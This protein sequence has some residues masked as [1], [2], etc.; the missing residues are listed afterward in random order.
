MN[1]NLAFEEMVTLDDCLFDFD[2][3]SVLDAKLKFAELKSSRIII[4]GDFDDDKWKLSDQLNYISLSFISIRFIF[5]H[6]YSNII[7]LDQNN[8][9]NSLKTFCV[10]NIGKIKN[11]TIQNFLSDLRKL[12]IID[13]NDYISNFEKYSLTTPYLD[14]IF[15]SS[16]PI[17]NNNNSIIQIINILESKKD[18]YD[19]RRQRELSEYDSYFL[20]NDI[21]K[22]YWENEITNVNKIYFFPLWLWWNLSTIIPI[23]PTEFVLIPRNCLQ[24][25]NGEYYLTI[26]RTNL[27]GHKKEIHN[28][29]DLDYRRDFI[30]IPEKIA[31]EIECYIEQTKDFS[32]CEINTLFNKEAHYLKYNNMLV[33]NRSRYY[34]Y[35][36]LRKALQLFYEEI[37][38]KKYGLRIVDKSDRYLSQGCVNRIHL[39]DTRHLA[40]QNCIFNFNDIEIAAA[41]AGHERINTTFHYVTNIPKMI[42]CAT[43]REYR[44]VFDNKIEYIFPPNINKT[45]QIN[46]S[47]PCHG[48]RCLSE[49]FITNDLEDCI[50][51][52]G[53][54]F[55]VGDCRGC[56][57][58]VPESIISYRERSLEVE[59]SLKLELKNFS[60]LFSHT[61]ETK[62]KKEKLNKAIL[63]CNN[64]M[65]QY[66]NACKILF[67]SGDFY[68]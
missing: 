48:G 5:T 10:F 64:L 11:R 4:Q 28:K 38:K 27:K 59:K 53:D 1:N 58:F 17:I 21:L 14:Y 37:I 52:S 12:L 67:E 8:L 44:R 57:F 22:D 9:V 6:Y 20:F 41:I 46:K 13:P 49:K 47:I 26:R 61:L 62:E 39:G 33:S 63:K 55:L 16:L 25:K 7:L 31:K 54:S 19:I 18:D 56:E 30:P 68:A 23:R 51:A 15:L 42:K 60:F 29:I 40:L 34:T 66:K 36:Y 45:N 65:N 32:K 2:E 35:F 50:N 3:F 43:Y 24:K